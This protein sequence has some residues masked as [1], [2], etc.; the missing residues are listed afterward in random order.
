MT[1]IALGLFMQESHSFT[2]ALGAWKGFESS[3]ILRGD[4][5][6]DTLEGSR[7]EMGAAIDVARAR[8]MEVVPLQAC[9]AISGGPLEAAMFETLVQEL[10]SR[11]RDAL[12]VDGVFVALHGGMLAEQADDA[13]GYILNAVR[14]VVGPDIPIAATLDLHANATQLMIDAANIVVGYHTFPHIDMYETGEKSMSLLCDTIDGKIKPIAAFKRIPMIVP[15]ETGATTGGPFGAVMQQA[16]ALESQPGILSASPFSV[17]PWLDVPDVGCGVI[18]IADGDAVLAEREADSIA[19]AFWQRR[20][21][22]AVQLTPLDEAIRRAVEADAG[23]FVLSDGADAPSSGAPGDSTAVLK[24]LLD[25]HVEVESLVNI[26]DPAAVAVAI[27][28]SVGADVT[29]TVGAQSSTLLYQPLTISGR[30]R[31]IADGDFRF[32]GPG[33]HGVEFHRGRTVVIQ[34]GTIYLEIM[35]QPVLQ[36]DPELY[37]SVGLEPRDARIVAVKSPTGFRAAYAPF[38]HEILLLDAP[39]VCSPNLLTFPWKRVRRPCFP[40]DDFSDWRARL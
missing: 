4:E 23:P 20:H 22:F 7:S 35:E 5:I 17:Q 32:K 37:R 38:A 21:E 14:Q 24:A 10:I 2:G 18:V 3:Y 34:I 26:V 15:G 39:G 19:D 36:W 9:N 31:L 16:I 33:F 8:G 1:R 40:F 29:L 6:L 13:S 11:V 12:P 28:A 25:A 27:T 30:V